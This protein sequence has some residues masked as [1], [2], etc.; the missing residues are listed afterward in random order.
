MSRQEENKQQKIIF[1]VSVLLSTSV[2]A[3]NVWIMSTEGQSLLQII[4]T[5][6]TTFATVLGIENFLYHLWKRSD[7]PAPRN[8]KSSSAS[9]FSSDYP[10]KFSV[11]IVI[12]IVSVTFSLLLTIILWITFLGQLLPYGQDLYRALALLGPFI[13][14]YCSLFLLSNLLLKQK[15][16]FRVP[17][18]V[19]VSRNSVLKRLIDYAQDLDGIKWI[20][21]YGIQG[22][23][24]TALL[25]QFKRQLLKK[26]VLRHIQCREIRFFPFEERNWES[27]L[28][29]GCAL[30]Y[31]EYRTIQSQFVET[32]HNEA[33]ILIDDFSILNDEFRKDFI[34]TLV[35][36]AN[37]NK[38]ILIITASRERIK[39]H[40]VPSDIEIE[41][42]S[43]ESL[44]IIEVELFIRQFQRRYPQK[45][46]LN[47]KIY[48]DIYENRNS[49]RTIRAGHP[50]SIA[51]I[52]AFPEIWE[53]VKGEPDR[54][55]E[56][57]LLCEATWTRLGAK[58]KEVLRAIAVISKYARDWGEDVWVG[59]VNGDQV[60]MRYI[61]DEL[62]D[63]NLVYQI[64]GRYRMHDI[65]QEYVYNYTQNVLEREGIHKVVGTFYERKTEDP[66]SSVF[67]LK[68]FLSAND[69]DGVMRVHKSA[70]KRLTDIGSFKE[71]ADLIM[72][73]LK[74]FQSAKGSLAALSRDEEEVATELLL[75]QG[76]AFRVIGKYALALE[77]LDHCIKILKTQS[78]QE[79]SKLLHIYE[80]RGNVY[81]LQGRYAEAIQEYEA[82]QK[83]AEVLNDGEGLA[84]AAY[85]LARIYRLQG[86]LEEASLQYEA[87]RI[88]FHK[89]GLPKQVW[90]LFGLGEIYRLE[91]EFEIAEDK[92][93]ESRR[94]FNQMGDK[95]GE[96][97]AAWG[98][99]EINRQ[100]HKYGAA[101]N[102]YLLS[103]ILCQEIG[104]RRSEVWAIMGL[105]EVLRM[106]HKYQEALSKYEE[107]LSKILSQEEQEA[108]EVAH[109]HLGIAASKRM[110]GRASPTDYEISYDTYVG[111][112]MQ[113][114]MVH[115]LIDRALCVISDW[116]RAQLDLDQADAICQE[117]GYILEEKLIQLIKKQRSKNEVHPLN[118]P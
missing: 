86:N 81:R 105:A 76:H 29:E 61:R 95:E 9:L 2:T 57:D 104:D 68:H 75:S 58:P 99:G 69:K 110:L 14:I 26:R 80:E 32:T 6:L 91:G 115:V 77:A 106:E 64:S 18:R 71:L 30:K 24:K 11:L 40:D 112:N 22:I 113:Q 20:Q 93:L 59:L 84:E 31:D 4:V 5:G 67:G 21:I 82:S 70:V 17:N 51:S 60:D 102:D 23:G 12:N 37:A 16:H 74:L 66:D 72:Q 87:A 97:Y 7:S 27:I 65:T 13:I 85:G 1:L 107:V 3:A 15:K 53:N 88:A 109:T 48:D 73:A 46:K 25:Q 28:R 54:V 78:D 96:A 45:Y 92:Y 117:K 42:M 114:C 98:T 94:Q 116:K 90:A 47:K 33:I 19:F 118:F 35:A 103:Q 79:N 100:L 111:H 39:R 52:L 34:N 108:I 41:P 62:V 44:S 8:K 38:S 50:Y 36:L 49:V 55:F 63:K 101:R 43:L 83:L 89:L 10:T 56:S